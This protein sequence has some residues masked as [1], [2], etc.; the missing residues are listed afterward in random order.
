MGFIHRGEYIK[1]P[2]GGAGVDVWLWLGA[3]E[4][5]TWVMR[6]RWLDGGEQIVSGLVK[7]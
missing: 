6:L 3:V 1:V 2:S 5:G 7:E 4:E